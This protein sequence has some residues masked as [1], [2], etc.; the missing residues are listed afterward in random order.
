MAGEREFD[1][2]M[3]AHNAERYDEAYSYFRKAAELGNPDG[4]D[5]VSEYLF[6]NLDGKGEDPE[7]GEYWLK[8]AADAGRAMSAHNLAYRYEQGIQV[9]VDELA[10]VHYYEIGI[11]GGV[12]M[13]AN[14]LA[15]MYIDGRGVRYN[16]NKAMEL[17]Q[18]AIDMDDNMY[19]YYNIGNELYKG[20]HVQRD[21]PTAVKYLE[22]AL[23][24]GMSEACVVLGE[25]YYSGYGVPIDKAK[26]IYYLTKGREMENPTCINNL[27]Y[28]YEE[29]IGVDKNEGKAIDLYYEAAVKGSV[30]GEYNLARCYFFGIGDDINDDQAF[31]W[32]KQAIEHGHP[33]AEEFYQ[34][35]LEEIN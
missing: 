24:L 32:I 5:A 6:K 2:G 12:S 10:A 7:Q 17:Y 28:C 11:E 3:A 26:T 31:Y 9:N 29:G 4:M 14:N 30:D 21:V 20:Q 1:L 23:E 13:S 33:Q 22:K 15:N 18:D 27:A 25:I 19:G 8:K 16:P 34:K 35:M